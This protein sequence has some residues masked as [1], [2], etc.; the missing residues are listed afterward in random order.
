MCGFGPSG[1]GDDVGFE[2]GHQRDKLLGAK[3]EK[4]AFWLREKRENWQIAS[5][6]ITGH[7]LKFSA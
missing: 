6:A 1:A 2:F 5:F 7:F 4:R 3:G